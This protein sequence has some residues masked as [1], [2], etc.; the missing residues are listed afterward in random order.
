MPIGNTGLAMVDARDIAEI[1]ASKLLRRE[2]ASGPLPADTI[3]IVGPDVLTGAAAA[4]IW[5]FTLAR[6]VS[7]AGDD[8]NVFEQMFRKFTP[9]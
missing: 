6:D 3:D 4:K 5:A 1:A 8:L 7:Y 2:R 9:E